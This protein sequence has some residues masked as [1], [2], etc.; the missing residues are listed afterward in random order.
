MA[1]QEGKTYLT[2]FTTLNYVVD[3]NLNDVQKYIMTV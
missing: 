3:S 1:Y 2:E